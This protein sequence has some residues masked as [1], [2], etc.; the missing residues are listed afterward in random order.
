MINLIAQFI[1][2]MHYVFKKLIFHICNQFLNDIKV[3]E[4]KIN[5]KKIKVLLNIQQ[6][7]FKHI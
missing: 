4:L 5:Y 7:M 6:F 3:K 1:K 2:I